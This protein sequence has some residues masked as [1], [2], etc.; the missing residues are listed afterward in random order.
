M[1]RSSG[2]SIGANEH[3]PKTRRWA[4]LT[5]ATAFITL[6]SMAG[7]AEPVGMG[8]AGG[9]A[10]IANQTIANGGATTLNGHVGLSPGSAYTGFETVTLNG[11][12][13]IADTDAGNAMAAMS[14]AYGN[15]AGQAVSATIGT[16]LGGTTVPGGGV[17][18]SGSGTFEITGTVILDGQDDP[19]AVF[20]FQMGGTLVTGAGATVSLINGAQACNV[21]WRVG[22]SAT[23]GA[24]NTFRGT[25]LAATSITLGAGST[26][27]GRALARDGSVTMSANTITPVGCA[28]PEEVT[29][30]TTI[31]ATTTTTAGTTTTTS[32]MVAGTTTSTVAGVSQLA[33]PTTTLAG[34][35][36]TI[37]TIAGPTTTTTT[38]AFPVGAASTGGGSSAAGWNLTQL[39]VGLVLLA[40]AVSVIGLRRHSLRIDS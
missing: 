13:H 2:V 21:Y 19:N 27:T 6:G 35:T 11:E 25:I 37:T 20:I 23:L 31:A 32:T 4:I 17:Y 28:P 39:A 34:P 1:I 9:Y 22:S 10:V 14:A 33:G 15:A 24:T 5:I 12:L 29:T 38:I 40:S 18:N 8:A 30:T 36:T 3:R 26:I 16:E 7:A